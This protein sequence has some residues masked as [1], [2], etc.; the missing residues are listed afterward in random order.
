VAEAMVGFGYKQGWL[1][2]RDGEPDKILGVI[3][4]H[5]VG[6]MGWRAGLDRAYTNDDLVVVTPQLPGADGAP[7]TLVAGRYFLINEQWVDAAEL[8]RALGGEVQFFATYRVR[9]LHRWARAVD[10]VTVRALRYVGETGE[11]TEWRGEPDQTELQI[12]LPP[13]YDPE[14]DVLVSEDDVMRLAAA[15]SV[16]PTSLDGRPAAGPLT[17]ARL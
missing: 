16:D 1:A 11:V 5:A 10:G 17:A 8:S 6:T 3:G 13:T 2:V 7:W 14:H 9:E 12:G 4:G 15:W